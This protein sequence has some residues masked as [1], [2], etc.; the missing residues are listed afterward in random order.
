M[1]MIDTIKDKTVNWVSL[2]SVEDSVKLTL[3]SAFLVRHAL[4]ALKPLV[5]IDPSTLYIPQLGVLRVVLLPGL[6]AELANAISESNVGYGL[7]LR[8]IDITIVMSRIS[9]STV[10]ILM[11]CDKLGLPLPPQVKSVLFCITVSSFVV[12]TL[13][14][15]SK[16][17]YEMLNEKEES[18]GERINPEPKQHS[19]Q[20]DA[21]VQATS[22]IGTLILFGLVP[23]A[24]P[25]G[26]LL[27]VASSSASLYM[28]YSEKTAIPVA[29]ASGSVNPHDNNAEDQITK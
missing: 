16:K 14:I 4:G 21:L 6:V 27:I 1:N 28:T 9:S 25:I 3:K 15:Y 23:V 7:G 2:P 26:S 20:M 5:D 8:A 10:S 12:E 11:G 13:G 19:S 18:L 17:G 29:L 22:I 24:A